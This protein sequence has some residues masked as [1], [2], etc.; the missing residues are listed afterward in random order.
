[1]TMPMS[2]LNQGVP[3]KVYLPSPLAPTAT[4]LAPIAVGPASSQFGLAFSG[5][6]ANMLMAKNAVAPKSTCQHSDWLSIR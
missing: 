4:M 2:V 3:E 6:L 5:S 1:M